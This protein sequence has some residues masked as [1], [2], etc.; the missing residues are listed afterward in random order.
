MRL[1]SSLELW[2]VGRSLD[3]LEGV[4]RA[5]KLLGCEAHVHC[6]TIHSRGLL[7]ALDGADVVL[8]QARYGGYR[9]REYDETF[10]HR[11]GMCG[12]EGLGLG[13]LAGAWRTWPHMSSLLDDVL[14]HSPRA[15]VVLM[16]APIS[17][18]SYIA[19]DQ[20]TLPSTLSASANCHG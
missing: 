7:R 4:K 17:I 6:A 20:L 2:L 8:L 1:G 15:L 9:A 19:S 3:R 14:A 10:P 16:T 12:D 13:G 5:G 18:S 11:Y